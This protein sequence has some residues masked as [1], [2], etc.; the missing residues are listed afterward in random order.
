MI[1]GWKAMTFFTG[2]VK[3]FYFGQST[4]GNLFYSRRPVMVMA[5]FL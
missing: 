4:L 1:D 3:G 5:H 2:F